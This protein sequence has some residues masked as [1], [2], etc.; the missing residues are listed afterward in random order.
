[1]SKIK[2][3]VSD[4][5][6]EKYFIVKKSDGLCKLLE[7]NNNSNLKIN[8]TYLFMKSIEEKDFIMQ[9][10]IKAIRVAN[11]VVKDI[12]KDKE[13]EVRKLYDL[14]K[15]PISL[16][17]IK[18]DFIN[19]FTND[20]NEQD[21]NSTE[22]KI[23]GKVV[24][25]DEKRGQYGTYCILT[26]KDITDQKVL[27]MVYHTKCD[28]KIGDV[29]NISKLKYT[30]R[31]KENM[32]TK[33]Q[34]VQ[35]TFNTKITK[36]QKVSEKLF[37]NISFGD[38]IKEGKFSGVSGSKIY[39]SCEHCF[40]KCTDEEPENLIICQKCN[41]LTKARK[42]YFV[43]IVLED[44]EDFI[45]LVIFRRSFEMREMCEFKA[46]ETENLEANVINFFDEK[47]ILVHANFDR[48]DPKGNKLIVV[49][50]YIM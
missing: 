24:R 35:T 25:V 43:E 9:G 17:E 11:I 8:K 38:V 32:K 40:S 29:V 21:T 10:S 3:K 27:I 28:L 26:L 30:K 20:N 39:F 45:Y 13:E 37:N 48:N 42:D 2:V 22:L 5:L 23:T 46:N 6:D 19:S 1:M 34:F 12:S 50:C 31:Q 4:I 14:K 49:K 47:R 16:E 36:I 7:T 15:K 33:E 41:K 18:P 44:K